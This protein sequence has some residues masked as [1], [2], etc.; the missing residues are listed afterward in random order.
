MDDE[1]RGA[2]TGSSLAEAK[3]AARGRHFG[4]LFR[5]QWVLAS[6][7]TLGFE[8]FLAT[9]I[10]RFVL[11]YGSAVRLSDILDERGARVGVLIGVA[12]DDTGA[13]VDGTLRI[14]AAVGDAE[15]FWLAAEARLGGLAGRYLAVID[16]GG[17]AR[18]YFDP[19]CDM[20]A[21]YD[22]EAGLLGSSLMLVLR[23][24]IRPNR[25]FN[26]HRIL[27]GVANFGFQATADEDVRRTIPNHYLDLRDW[28]FHRHWPHASDRFEAAAADA[29]E[30][31]DRMM[32]RLGAIT[33]ALVR[34][35][36]CIMPV[37]GGRDSRMLLAASMA[38]LGHV[39]QFGAFR[40][41]NPSRID[42]RIGREITNA[43]GFEFTQYFFRPAQAQDLKDFRLKS[44][45]HGYRGELLAL[46]G[47]LRFPKDHLVLRGNIMELMRAN[48]WRERHLDKPFKLVHGMKR[49]KFVAALNDP[50]DRAPWEARYQAWRKTLP[51][52]A[53]RKVYDF[54]FLE[55]LLPNTQGTYFGG[56]HDTFFINPFNDRS[57][58]ADAIRLP[59]D[60]RFRNEVVMMALTR[61]APELLDFE[62]L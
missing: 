33:G 21:V 15:A 53:Q 1:G 34:R 58:I 16:T 10:G 23:R 28:T 12:V 52:G 24:P 25:D 20:G 42:A 38:D 60:M 54:G 48:Q 51:D 9:S 26:L 35:F 61:T 29:G 40:F 45:Y 46:D 49:A 41:H 56:Y 11:H 17:A 62:F 50:D 18:A 2:V 47:A 27:R 44:G 13:V 7:R 19:V 30:I 14:G 22:R 6:G 31:V 5:Q 39:R 57:L 8:G 37:T 36:D 4:E 55:H 43:L 3:C 32:A 59:A